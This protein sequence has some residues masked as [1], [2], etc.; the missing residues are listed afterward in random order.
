MHVLVIGAAGMVG[1]KLVEAL[2]AKGEINGKLVE[3]LTLADV[4]EPSAP[5]ASP[6][7]PRPCA[8]DLSE[9]GRRGEADR[10][11]AGPDLPSGG[12]RVRRSR[13]RLRE[14]LPGQ[15]R[16]HA[17]RCSRRS[18][19]E[20]KKS[21]YKPKLVFTSSIAVFG[22]P[23]PDSHRR[24][25]SPYAADQLRHAEGD[26]RAAARRLFAARLLRRHRHTPA[27]HR[28]PPRQAQ[29]GGVGLLLQHPARAAVGTWRPCCRSRKACG[30]GSPARARRSASCCMRPRSIRQPSAAG[31]R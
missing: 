28:Y 29:Q 5:C 17:R 2:V 25:A 15:S 8:A 12:H 18:R 30:T 31:V 7:R 3:R 14:G 19:L 1:R 10:R 20:G 6:A 23:L 22:E 27:D 9:R 26:R 13:G 24:H 4:V 11:A 16:R 21:P